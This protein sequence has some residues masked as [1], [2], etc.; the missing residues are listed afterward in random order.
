MSYIASAPQSNGSHA[1]HL[2]R[3]PPPHSSVKITFVPS[4]LKVAECQY[5]KPTSVTTSSLSGLYGSEISNKIPFPE[6]APA[7]RLADGNTVMSWHWF[8]V[9]VS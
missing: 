5:A 9:F 4:L 2:A 6:Q 8:V 3:P 7:A 1:R